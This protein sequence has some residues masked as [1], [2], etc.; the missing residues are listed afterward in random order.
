MVRAHRQQI[1][2]TFSAHRQRRREHSSTPKAIRLALPDDLAWLIH[3]SGEAPAPARQRLLLPL[4]P[5]KRG[6]LHSLLHTPD[7]ATTIMFDAEAHSLISPLDLFMPQSHPLS[8]LDVDPSRQ[9]MPS[10]VFQPTNVADTVGPA[11]LHRHLSLH[12]KITQT[13]CYIPLLHECRLSAYVC[14]LLPLPDEDH[15]Q[16]PRA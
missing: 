11:Y 15:Y 14:H 7:L 5:H 10:S 13:P 1:N 16:R 6:D 9:Q 12:P 2:Q 4:S 8:L 3:L